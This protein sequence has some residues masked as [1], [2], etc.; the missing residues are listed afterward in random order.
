MNIQQLSRLSLLVPL[1]LATGALMTCLDGCHPGE[2]GNSSRYQ[3]EQAVDKD[4]VVR[5]NMRA[6]QVA[7]EH[8]AADHGSNTYPIVLDDNFKTYL[9][10]G[11]ERLKPSP[12][13]PVNPFTGFN[14]FP[15][16]G[17]LNSVLAV[18][19]GPRFEIQAGRIVYSP[20]QHGKGY[21]IVG[22]AHDGKALMDLYHPGQVLVFTNVPDQ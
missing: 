12:V 6:V 16:L 8:F 7:A 3:D 5:Q 19:S 2:K 9:P 4:G 13:G 11:I 14:E 10:G 18:R 20:L 17:N 1:V 22:G 21:A 15:T